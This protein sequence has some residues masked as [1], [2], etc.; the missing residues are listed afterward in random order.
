MARRRSRY[1]A[2]VLTGILGLLILGAAYPS[3]RAQEPGVT[4]LN[5]PPEFSSLDIGSRSGLHYIDVVISDYNSWGDIFQ[6]DVEVLNEDEFQIAHVLY[7]QYPDNQTTEPQD[8]F[9]EPLGEILVR[10]QSS[11]SRDTDPQTVRE[12]TEMHVTIVLSQV[13]GRWLRVTA[14][15]LGGLTALAQVEYLTG[16]IGGAGAVPPLVIMML[17]LA[18]SVVVVSSRLRRERS[19]H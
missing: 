16:V 12:K 13:N 8:E 4:V 19:G 1:S 14:T 11:V 5:V 17:A 2:I 9:L 7:R 6:L 18:A 10:D 15:D 3:A